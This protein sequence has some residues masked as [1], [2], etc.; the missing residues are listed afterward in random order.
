MT[1]WSDDLEV[2]LISYLGRQHVDSCNAC[3]TQCA[4]VVLPHSSSIRGSYDGQSNE[5]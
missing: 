3:I 2:S 4:H 1:V 5:L